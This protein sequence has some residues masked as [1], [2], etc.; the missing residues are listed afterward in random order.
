VGEDLAHGGRVGDDGDDAHLRAAERAEKPEADVGSCEKHDT[1][2]IRSLRAAATKPTTAYEDIEQVCRL[3][4]SGPI[5]LKNSISGD[6][7]K[8]AAPMGR[9]AC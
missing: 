5:L 2:L 9:A 3:T 7:E 8:I 6:A 1:E 4:A